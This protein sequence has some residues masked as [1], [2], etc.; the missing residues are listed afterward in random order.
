MG[1]QFVIH[2]NQFVLGETLEFVK[3]PSD[4]MAYV[5][6]R[7]TWGRTGLIVATAVGIQPNFRGVITLELRNLGDVPLNLYPGTK[8]LQLFFHTVTP[9]APPARRTYTDAFETGPPKVSFDEQINQYANLKE[10]P[11][12]TR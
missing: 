6:T 12:L 5:V 7:S 9:P 8:I 10:F 4:M 1:Q 2:P 11:F 3:L